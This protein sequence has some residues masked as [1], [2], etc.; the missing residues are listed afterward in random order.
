MYKQLKLKIVYAACT[1]CM[2]ILI[3]SKRQLLRE[4][5][6]PESFAN[7]LIYLLP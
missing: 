2:Y 1:G 4:K 7:A 3:I 5:Y 6:H